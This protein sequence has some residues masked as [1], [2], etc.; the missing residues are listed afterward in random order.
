MTF[1]DRSI[2]RKRCGR[3]APERQVSAP[4]SSAAASR[5][6]SIPGRTANAS[7][8]FSAPAASTGTSRTSPA[9]V[10]SRQFRVPCRTA[11]RTS[12][13]VRK[14]HEPAEGRA[15]ITDLALVHLD[16]AGRRDPAQE[17]EPSERDHAPGQPRPGS[18]PRRPRSRDQPPSPVSQTPTQRGDRRDHLAPPGQTP[19]PRGAAKSCRLPIARRVCRESRL[20]ANPPEPPARASARR[21][22]PSRRAGC[23]ARGRPASRRPAPAAGALGLGEPALRSDQ[24]R[25][26][27][28]RPRMTRRRRARA[29]QRL[30]GPKNAARGVP[31]ASSLRKRITFCHL[32]QRSA[33]ALL[34]R[35]ADM[36]LSLSRRIRSELVNSVCTG[37]SRATPSSTAF[38]TMKSVRAFLTGREHQPEIGRRPAAA[39]AQGRSA[40]PCVCRLGDLGQPL[41]VAPVENQNFGRRHLPHHPEKVMRLRLGRGNRLPRPERVVYTEPDLRRRHEAE[42][43]SAPDETPEPAGPGRRRRAR[44]LGR[45]LG[46]GPSRGPICSWRAPTGRSGRGCCCSRAGGRRRWRSCR[47][48]R[49]TPIP[50]IWRSSSSAPSSCAGRAA[51]GTTSSTATMT[52]PWRARPPTDP[53][54]PGERR[55]RLWLL[56]SGCRSSGSACCCSSTPRPS[57]SAIASLGLVAIYPFTKRFTFWPQLVLGLTFKWGALLAC[58]AH[59]GTVTGPRVLLYASGIAWTIFYDTIYAHQDKEDDVLI[60]VKSTAR[61]FGACNRQTARPVPDP[62]R[63]ADVRGDPRGS[64]PH[65]PGRSNSPSRSSRPGGSAGIFCGRC[66]GSTPKTRPAASCFSGPTAI[67]G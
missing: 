27:A 65:V 28:R 37:R 43:M 57:G 17:P 24:D 50:G 4:R 21:P 29:H 33:A 53:V 9:V 36:G 15:E 18:P 22:P 48:G 66:G 58:A 45:P 7:K 63:H 26:G 19:W 51:P 47:R 6:M 35:L 59:S 12:D 64:S 41:A 1:R 11:N 25:P 46:A 34:G 52:R 3:A 60:G 42:L 23:V 38:S 31:S 61:L 56:A 55:A 20:T 30:V 13:K 62:F 14:R 39:S 10:F 49:P 8:S 5:A 67:P 2:P 44:Q 40:R 32:R 54:G 16:H